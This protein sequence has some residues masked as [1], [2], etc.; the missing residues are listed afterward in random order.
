M[1][2]RGFDNL[3]DTVFALASPMR[4]WADNQVSPF[5]RIIASFY[6]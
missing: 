6:I 2:L 1:C 3:C 4:L 5:L